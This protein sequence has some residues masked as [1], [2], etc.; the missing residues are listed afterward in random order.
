MV[1]KRSGFPIGARFGVLVGV[2]AILVCLLLTDAFRCQGIFKYFSSKCSSMVKALSAP[3]TSVVAVQRNFHV[4]APGVWRSAQPNPESLRKMKL[5]GLKT[6]VNLRLDGEA[7]PWENE[8]AGELGVRY[9]QFPL[10]ASLVVPVKTVDA[11][12]SI[13]SDPKYQPVLIHCHA[14]KD[15]T[16][17]IVAAYKIENTGWPFRDIYQE[18]KMYGYDEILFP[19]MLKTLRLWSAAHGRL[20]EAQEIALV[21]KK[22]TE[23]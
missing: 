10:S 22:L 13:L 7:E 1:K 5:H 19:E 2:L 9:Y 16:G 21:E 14:G 3:S 20:Q 18:M 15:R 8:L 23:R 11:V 4:V 17:M 12:L 6:L